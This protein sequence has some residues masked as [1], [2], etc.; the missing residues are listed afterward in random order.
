MLP[1][2]VRIDIN[3]R[4]LIQ[5]LLI[6]SMQPEMCMIMKCSLMVFHKLNTHI[7]TSKGKEPMITWILESAQAATIVPIT[8]TPRVTSPDF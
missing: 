6:Y 8:H 3:K 5:I 7:I 1:T 2:N 4:S